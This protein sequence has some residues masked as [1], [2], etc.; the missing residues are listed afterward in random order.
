MSE[1]EAPEQEK[2]DAFSEEH[3]KP[4]SEELRGQVIRNF[5]YT[6]LDLSGRAAQ[7]ILFC[8]VIAAA[9]ILFPHGK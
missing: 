7:S 8:T 3:G 2:T 9:A 6:A 1:S 4:V 5:V